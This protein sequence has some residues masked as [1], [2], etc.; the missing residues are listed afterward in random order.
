MASIISHDNIVAFGGE[1]GQIPVLGTFLIDPGDVHGD[2]A[3]HLGLCY[4]LGRKAFVDQNW[5][6]HAATG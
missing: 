6:H 3:A 4:R 1:G 5:I 2:K